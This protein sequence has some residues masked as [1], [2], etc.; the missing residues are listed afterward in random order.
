MN[1]ETST[2]VA[3]QINKLQDLFIASDAKM[4]AR[5]TAIDQKLDRFNETKADKDTVKDLAEKQDST[6]HKVTRHSTIF[7]IGWGFLATLLGITI[8]H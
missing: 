2:I 1:E 5:L 6:A 7:A 4:E 3:N 8:K